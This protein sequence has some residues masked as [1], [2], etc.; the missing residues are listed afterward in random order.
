MHIAICDSDPLFCQ[1]I[2]PLLET[3]CEDRTIA[4]TLTCYHSGEALLKEA[5]TPDL[6]LL[7]YHLDGITGLET[8]KE[9]RRRQGSHICEVIFLTT[10]PNHALEAFSVQAGGYLLKPTSYGQLEAVLDRSMARFWDCTRY[11]EIICNRISVKIPIQSIW[12]AEVRKNL[13][14]IHTKEQ[15]YQT[16]LALEDLEPLLPSWSFLRCHRSYLVHLKYVDHVEDNNFILQDG[17][18]IPMRIREKI[19]MRQAYQNYLFQRAQKELWRKEPSSGSL[20]TTMA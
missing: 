19:A 6:V 12:Y 14:I 11:I 10:D 20:K 7:D 4:A 15:A 16:Y 18:Q 17:T 2:L 3:Y 9:L 5:T 13:T 1:A 8:A